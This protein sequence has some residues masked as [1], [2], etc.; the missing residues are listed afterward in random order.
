MS[1]R[2]RLAFAAL[3]VLCAQAAPAQQVRSALTRDS[4][5]VGDIIGVAV[6]VMVPFGWELTTPDTLPISGDVENAA[7]RR[8]RI[9]TLQ[10]GG[11]RYL[12]TYPIAAWRP[13]SYPL[14]KLTA[15]LSANGQQRS[16]EITTPTLTVASVLPADTA[17]IQAK[18]PRDVWGASRLWWPLV[19]L[20]LLLVA[21][22]AALIWWWRRRRKHVQEEPIVIAPPISPKE[23]VLQEIDRIV[24]ARYLD[25]AD[26]RGFYID[27]T[28]VMRTYVSRLDSAWSTDLTTTELAGHIGASGAPVAALFGVLNRADLVKFARHRPISSEAHA[29]IEALRKWV[30]TFEKP[31][32]LA[33]AA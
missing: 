9:D 23:W 3:L 31:L 16:I 13:G 14:P 30:D 32:P 12:I 2:L 6:E 17:N 33:V 20:A 27:L 24:A 8:V 25:R 10:N 19:L 22:I 11:Y 18:P 1:T 29:D 26:F 21:V 4:A 15:A 7:H 5:N 28:G